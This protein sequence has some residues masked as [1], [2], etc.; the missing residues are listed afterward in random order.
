MAVIHT[1][2]HTASR[3]LPVT[4]SRSVESNASGSPHAWMPCTWVSL[5]KVCVLNA[6]IEAAT[7]AALRSPRPF[8]D[9]RKHR[10]GRQR[11]AEEQDDVVGEHR[12]RTQP[13]Q[14]CAHDSGHDQRFR[15]RQR[16]AR[17]VEDVRVEEVGRRSRKLM[18]DPGQ[19]PLVELSVAVVVAAPRSRSRGQRPGVNDRQTGADGRSD[20]P[21]Q[22][23]CAASYRP[24]MLRI[25]VRSMSMATVLWPPV[26]MM[27]SA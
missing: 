11:E 8:I 19:N 9:E 22:R 17:G 14:R 25:S 15:K 7:S 6:K 21:R 12:R 23:G 2:S 4:I 5:V 10:P 26:G 1:A 27:M 3:S 18:R 24:A 16:V 20:Q 13:V